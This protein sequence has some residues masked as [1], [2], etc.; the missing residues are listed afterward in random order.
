MIRTQSRFTPYLFM[1]PVIL[2]LTFVF[3]YPLVRNFDF[4]FRQIR[5]TTGPWVGFRNYELVLGQE[6]FQD[7]VKHNLQL[8]LGVPVIVTISFVMGVILVG[9]AR[10][11]QTYRTLLFMP[12]IL[13][14][15]V[16]AVVLKAVFQFNG[17]VNDVLRNLGAQE[18]ALDW[19]GSSDIALWTVLL[20]IIWRELGFGI[21]LM[22][23]GLLN[24]DASV[25]EAAEIDGANWWQ[26]LR[27]VILP[28]M[29][30]VIEF[31][32]VIGVITMLSA[33]FAYIY[34]ISAG[35]GGPGTSTM[36]TELY[37][38]NALFRNSLP[39]VAAAVSVMMFV[40]AAGAIFVLFRLRARGADA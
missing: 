16:V 25:L 39:G 23:A 34:M 18:L 11:R 3:G 17:P 30:S 19:I 5:G 13:S 6:L 26:R 7:A 9:Q 40:V 38:F 8:L 20:V 12:Y 14:I 37:V 29:A 2:L 33:V 4:S 32:V 1:A 21:V 27:Y 22:L 10:G 36:V 28:Q 24:L 31:Y 35:R 15:P